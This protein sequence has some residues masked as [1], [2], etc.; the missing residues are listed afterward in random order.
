MMPARKVCRR[1]IMP[2]KQAETWKKGLA[3]WGQ[4]GSRIQRLRDA[5]DMLIFTP[6]SNAGFPVSILKSFAAPPQVDP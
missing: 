5:V 6:G 3:G 1:W 4:D 2:D